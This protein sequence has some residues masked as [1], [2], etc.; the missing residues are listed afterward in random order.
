[1]RCFVDGTILKTAVGA[2]ADIES[3]SNHAQELRIFQML[4]CHRV[5]P[6]PMS[7]EGFRQVRLTI[8]SP[9]MGPMPS[10]GTASRK[11]TRVVYQSHTTI[12]QIQSLVK[13]AF[14]SESWVGRCPVLSWSWRPEAWCSGVVSSCGCSQQK[15]STLPVVAGSPQFWSEPFSIQQ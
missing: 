3:L 5:L 6:R 1:M 9:Y 12:C 13:M 11:R 8:W 10:F 4:G 2:W 15:L 7:Q 14:T